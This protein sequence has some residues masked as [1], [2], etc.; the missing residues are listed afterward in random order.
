MNEEERLQQIIDEIPEELK[1]PKCFKKIERQ[2]NTPLLKITHTHRGKLCKR[3]LSIMDKN[4][5]H[6]IEVRQKLGFKTAE[7]YYKWKQIMN[8]LV[9]KKPIRIK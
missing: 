9:N 3:C 5:R 7:H 4:L 2:I 6:R 8:T 1:D